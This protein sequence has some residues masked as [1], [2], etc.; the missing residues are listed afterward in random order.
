MNTTPLLY[1]EFPQGGLLMADRITTRIATRRVQ[2]GVRGERRAQ[3]AP[4]HRLHVPSGTPDRAAVQRRGR[5]PAHL[6]MPLRR[7]L[8]GC[9]TDPSRRPRQRAPVRTHWDMLLERRSIPELEELL[10]ERLALLRASRGQ[11]RDQAHRLSARRFH[12]R[13]PVLPPGRAGDLWYAV[14]SRLSRGR[15]TGDQSM[16]SPSMT[17]RGGRTGA[18]ARSIPASGPAARLR[19]ARGT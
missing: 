19:A 11:R 2:H 15:T 1:D 17:L 12:R 4:D 7:R 18:V 9:S 14:G 5:R 10:Q 8:R 16:I 6:G 13:R 3:R